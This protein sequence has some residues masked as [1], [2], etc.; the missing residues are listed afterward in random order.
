MDNPFFE[1]SILNSPYEYPKRHWELDDDRMR[2]QMALVVPSRQRSRMEQMSLLVKS[3]SQHL[4]NRQ[5]Q[6][7]NSNLKAKLIT[8][9]GR[10]ILLVL[11]G[12]QRPRVFIR[13]LIRSVTYGL[14]PTS[15]YPSDIGL[16][17]YRSRTMG[18]ALDHD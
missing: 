10:H 8:I 11:P 5:I 6:G 4:L 14:L 17:R 2:V 12:W 16:D 13:G 9:G 15:R 3:I 18:P 7:L 1:H